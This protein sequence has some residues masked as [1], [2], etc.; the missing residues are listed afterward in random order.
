MDSGEEEKAIGLINRAIKLDSLNGDYYYS[1]AR[2]R[3]GLNA[4]N[5][6]V[7]HLNDSTYNAAMGDLNYARILD[8]QNYM[9]YVILEARIQ[10][11]FGHYKAAEEAL[12]KGFDPNASSFSLGNFYMVKSY[13]RRR[14][15]EIDAAH[16][17]VEKALKEDS[18]S[19]IILNGAA[20]QY[21]ELGEHQKALKLINKILSKHPDNQIAW[22]NIAFYSL[23]KGHYQK[24]IDLF[25][26]LIEKHP[27]IGI[28]Y[29][30]RS[31]AY[32][33][34]GQYKK[35]LL[36]VNQAIALAPGNSYAY[37][38]R[39]LIYLAM[40]KSEQ[41]CDDLQTAKKLKYSLHY[42]DLVIKLLVDNCLKINQKVK[43]DSSDARN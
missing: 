35:A 22:M 5:V 27:D 18:T 30:N 33:H 4:T 11:K 36:D 29:N 40:N 1:R 37:K 32:Y 21:M 43:V 42:D 6:Q 8:G 25:S 41:A 23:E 9:D 12:E 20:F 10:I 34:L 2:I 17:N 14:T 3:S 16:E 39:A 13:L 38:N 31:E 15:N 24:A 7:H 19:I 28:S 26:D